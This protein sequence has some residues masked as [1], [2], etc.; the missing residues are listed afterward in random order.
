M[1]L[2]GGVSIRGASDSSRGKSTWNI[3]LSTQ[4]RNLGPG[5]VSAIEN[6][7]EY[8]FSLQSKC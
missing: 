4:L 6:M 2:I 1:A 7:R 8:I 5:E 3:I